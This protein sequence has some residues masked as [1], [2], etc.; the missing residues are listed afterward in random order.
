MDIGANEIRQWHQAKGWQD[1]GYHYV[2]RRDGTTEDGCSIEEIGAHVRGAN[3]KSIGICLVGGI[4]EDGLPESNFT[5]EQIQTLVRCIK[6]FK[7]DYPSAKAVGHRDLLATRS[8]QC[9]CF[10]VQSL[11]EN[12]K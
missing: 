1:I 6:T 11:L 10:D 5:F 9:P 4:S 12:T 3:H 7:Q 8:K 2:I